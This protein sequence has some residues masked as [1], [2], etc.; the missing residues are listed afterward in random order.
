MVRQAVQVGPGQGQRVTTYVRPGSTDPAFATL[1]FRDGKTGRRV[2]SD[3]E[4][5]NLLANKPPN[6]LTSE[7]YQLV[8]LGQPQGLMQIPTLPGLQRQQQR[9][10]HGQPRPRG[11]RGHDLGR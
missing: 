10:G 7:D 4:I 3:V 1:V 9:P 11:G 8:A 2:I 5:G 6:A